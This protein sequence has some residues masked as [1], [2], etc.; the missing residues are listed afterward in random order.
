MR[1]HQ[2]EPGN[3]Y[4]RSC[5]APASTRY[6][7]SSGTWRTFSVK[8]FGQRDRL[9]LPVSIPSAR[10]SRGDDAVPVD[11]ERCK[12]PPDLFLLEAVRLDPGQMHSL[13]LWRFPFRV[14][15]GLETEGSPGPRPDAPAG[16]MVRS[17]VT[18]QWEGPGRSTRPSHGSVP[19]PPGVLGL[20]V[21]R[22]DTQESLGADTLVTIICHK[23]GVHPEVSQR[24][25]HRGWPLA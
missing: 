23:C 17:V 13:S 19:A 9:L 25:R 24:S 8:E 16:M 7:Q 20:G 1:G 14:E 22:K 5:G 11:R 15:M 2:R 10:R 4:A 18:L 21:S 6:R 12:L 3:R